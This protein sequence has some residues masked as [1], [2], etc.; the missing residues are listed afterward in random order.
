VRSPDAIG[1]G[2]MIMSAIGERRHASANEG[3]GF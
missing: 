2:M 1:V 3:D